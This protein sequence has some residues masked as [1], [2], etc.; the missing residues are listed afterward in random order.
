MKKVF[1]TFLLVS[2]NFVS[3]SE[4]DEYTLIGPGEGIKYQ[5]SYGSYLKTT[6]ELDREGEVA[7]VKTC[8][9]GE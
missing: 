5:S 1:I 8:N 6:L 9:T 2:L 4:I 7:F 3:A